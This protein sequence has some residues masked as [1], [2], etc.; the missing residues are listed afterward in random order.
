M[1]L[2]L[3]RAG[4]Y[5]RQSHGKQTSLDDQDRANSGRCKARGWTVAKRYSDLVSAS[6]FG[7][8]T[9]GDWDQL[10]A[11]V[12]AGELDIVVLWDTA[13]GDRT[14]ESWAAFLST[15]RDRGVLIHATSYDRTFD[16]RISAH[17]R[18]AALDGVANQY[19]SEKR[20]TDVLRGVAGAAL[21]GK[22]HGRSAWGYRRVYNESDRKVF[23]EIPDGNAE[24]VKEI[25]DRIARR[26]PINAIV[27]D[28]TA[29]GV[30]TPNWKGVPWVL[31]KWHRNSLRQVAMRPTYAGLRTHNGN[32]HEGNWPAIVDPE[33]WR[34][35]QSV[36]ED[37]SRKTTQPGRFKWLLSYILVAECGQPM[38]VRLRSPGHTTSYRCV[39]DGCTSLG[40][41][42]ADTYVTELV[43]AR[44]VR[45]DA[46]EVFASDDAEAARCRANVSRVQDEHV[47]LAKQVKAGRLSA[48]FAAIAEPGILQRLADAETELKRHTR[49]GALLDLIE[50][51]D[52]RVAWDGLSVAGRRSVIGMLFERLE[53][54]PP[55]EYLTRW[56]TQ[57]DRV[58]VARERVS[59][60]WA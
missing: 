21:A 24:Y 48:T 4:I 14:V 45:G 32:L 3:R 47:D 57:E 29:R 2:D 27:K 11:D 60:T 36:L 51:D 13:R 18:D 43:L 9:R 56:S 50:A 42:E 8:R 46:R 23:T 22:A 39:V 35:A 25:I 10:V 5:N 33:V 26:D 38:N 49:H 16:P 6:R 28:L 37:P 41:W 19:E 1:T 17:W 59:E 53:A 7:T 31:S 15:C 20:S 52:I 34:E 54:G 58:R 55:T 40:M 44:L 12:A 30:P